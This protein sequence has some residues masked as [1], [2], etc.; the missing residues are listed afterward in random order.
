MCTS[1]HNVL[2][3]FALVC[4]HTIFGYKVVLATNGPQVAHPWLEVGD[5]DERKKKRWRERSR[6]GNLEQGGE[7][8]G[9]AKDRGKEVD[10]K[11]NEEREKVA[12]GW[13][14]NMARWWAKSAAS[15]A[16]RCS[17]I[18]CF[19]S[20]ILYVT[21]Q[22]A[23]CFLTLHPGLSGHILFFLPQT[24]PGSRVWTKL[25]S[26]FFCFGHTVAFLP[27]KTICAI[28]LKH[29][30]HPK[31]PRKTSSWHGDFSHASHSKRMVGRLGSATNRGTGTVLWTAIL[32][33]QWD[34]YKISPYLLT[35]SNLPF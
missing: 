20:R 6:M 19:I 4:I 28:D 32:Q 9:K 18:L 34:L 22:G 5:E 26:G 1:S 29:L 24:L 16:C 25:P 15:P 2:N 13:E 21:V 12:G 35:S 17:E 10:E 7:D 14:R 30:L 11:E 23:H 31:K 8:N 33:G 27:F 3:K